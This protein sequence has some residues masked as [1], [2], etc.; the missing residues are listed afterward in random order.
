MELFRV[1]VTKF[2]NIFLRTH[3]K[4]ILGEKLSLIFYGQNLSLWM[5][6]S[7]L[8]FIIDLFAAEGLR[9]RLRYRPMIICWLSPSRSIQPITIKYFREGKI[10]HRPE[11]E[12]DHVISDKPNLMFS[13]CV[14]HWRSGPE[15]TS[16]VEPDESLAPYP[17][18]C[19]FLYLAH[20]SYDL[21]RARIGK[22]SP[23][24]PGYRNLT[25]IP[26]WE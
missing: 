18:G 24:H 8:A 1:L 20:D 9:R 16:F 23:P 14:K 6:P 5:P 22:F 3:I 25:K 11:S 15:V 26:C 12:R 2:R 21:G 13:V 7:V 17:L 19:L 4:L 10:K